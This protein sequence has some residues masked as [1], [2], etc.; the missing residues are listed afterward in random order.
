MHVRLVIADDDASMRWLIGAALD[1][2]AVVEVARG[3]DALAVARQ[4]RPDLVLLDVEMP[5]LDGL[6]VAAA[7][8]EDAA[9]AAIPV[10]LCSGAGR[11]AAAAAR[12]LPN[13]VG[14]LAKPFSL[15]ALQTLVDAA[16][17]DG[18]GGSGGPAGVT[19]PGETVLWYAAPIAVAPSPDPA[20]ARRS[21]APLAGHRHHPKTGHGGPPVA[22][23]TT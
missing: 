9:T 22:G 10:V 5:G 11:A 7:L 19:P 17:E 1:G 16:L 8:A 18:H 15:R 14:F 23:A 2:Y 13:V 6:A 3:D 4:E 21:M 20:G 12:R